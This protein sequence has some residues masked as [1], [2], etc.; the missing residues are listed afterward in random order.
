VSGACFVPIDWLYTSGN[1]INVS[2]GESGYVWKG[3]GVNID[4]IFL[5]GYNYNLGKADAGGTLQ[6][7]IATLISQWKPTFLRVSLYLDTPSATPPWT[8]VTWLDAGGGTRVQ[9]TDD[10]G[11]Q[12]HRQPVRLRSRDAPE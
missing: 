11:H 3:R 9:D 7:I 10:R 4:D 6:T 1:T 2:N 8:T 5:G 12:L